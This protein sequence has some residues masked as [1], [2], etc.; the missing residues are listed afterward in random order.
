MRGT[1]PALEAFLGWQRNKGSQKTSRKRH[2][3][4]VCR[5]EIWHVGGGFPKEEILELELCRLS[6]YLPGEERWG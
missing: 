4:E 1:P 2:C 3:L 6:R 5:K